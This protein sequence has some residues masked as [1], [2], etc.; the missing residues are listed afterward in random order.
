MTHRSTHAIERM[1]AG[2]GVEPSSSGSKPDMLPVTPSRNREHRGTGI[3]TQ[4][5]ALIWRYG[6]LIRQLPNE[7][8]KPLSTELVAV[9]GIEPTS[10][11]YQSSAL[12]VELHRD[13]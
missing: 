3:R 10:L 11:D 6:P 4:N 1:A 5:L 13:G 12:S 8:V 9:E 7:L 2:E